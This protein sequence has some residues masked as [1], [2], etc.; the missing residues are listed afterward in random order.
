MAIRIQ[1]LD[2]KQEFSSTTGKL[3]VLHFRDLPFNPLRIYWISDVNSGS[4]RGGHAHKEL[5]QVFVVLSGSLTIKIWD[6][7]D[8]LE[9]SLD[10]NSKPLLVNPGYW[11][12]LQDFTFGTILLV[13]VDKEYDES[14]YIRDKQEFLIWNSIK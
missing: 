4:V 10:E 9:H 8:E 6:G 13:L 3:S 11:R 5:S 1:K 14:D 7:T 2:V 12:D